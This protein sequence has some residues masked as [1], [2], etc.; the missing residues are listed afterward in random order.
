MEPA[1]NFPTE[2]KIQ[3]KLPVIETTNLSKLYRTGFWMNQKIES[4]KN[5]NLTVYQGETFGLLGQNGAGKTTLLKTLLGIVR[6][7]SGS[8]F[9]LGQPIGDRSVKAKIGYLP[10]N[11]Y[12]YDYLTGWEFLEFVAGLFKISKSIQKQRISELLDLVGL[13]RSTAIRKQLRQYSKGMLQRVGMAQAL[14]NDPELVFLDEPMS[15]LDP[16]GRYQI[17]EIIVSLNK[18]GKTIFFNSHVLSDVEKICDRIAILA[19]GE[20]ICIRTMEEILS[21]DESCCYVKGRNGNFEILKQWIPDLEFENNFWHG[22]LQGDPQEFLV[23]LGLMK[24]TLITMN[25]ERFSLE[26]Y[27]MQQL[28]ERGIFSTN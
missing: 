11:P 17:R 14:I 24:A 23:S 9:L 1:V 21:T 25:I 20:L 7:T 13:S 10:E 22:H 16:M 18:L 3:E 6:P 5:C 8:G 28:R 15:G 12:F 27:F 26:E 2:P 4:L 19:E